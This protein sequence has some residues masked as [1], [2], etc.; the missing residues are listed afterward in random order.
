MPVRPSIY[1]FKAVKFH[2]GL[3]LDEAKTGFWDCPLQ[4]LMLMNIKLPGHSCLTKKAHHTN[5]NLLCIYTIHLNASISSK[6]IIWMSFVMSNILGDE[7]PFCYMCFFV[8]LF[9]DW[10]CFGLVIF[11]TESKRASRHTFDPAN[12]RSKYDIWLVFQSPQWKKV[13]TWMVRKSPK[14]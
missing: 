12:Y 3:T 2:K 4:Y 8:C 6:R 14:E 11:S 10:L 9:K 7:A 5:L 13:S 1:K